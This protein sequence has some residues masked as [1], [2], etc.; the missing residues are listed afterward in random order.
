MRC[1]SDDRHVLSLAVYQLID[2]AADRWLH[3]SANM[4][5]FVSIVTIQVVRKPPR[6]Q[7]L[8]SFTSQVEVHLLT[9]L[10]SDEPQLF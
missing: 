8:I 9:D 3:N 5:P 10:R 6:L 2:S 4:P 1:A 7:T